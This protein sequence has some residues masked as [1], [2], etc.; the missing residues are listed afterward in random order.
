MGKL[1]GIPEWLVLVLGLLVALAAFVVWGRYSIGKA[2]RLLA[3]RRPSP[4]RE[5]FLAMLA[6]DVDEDVALWIWDQTTFYYRP[7]TP[8]PDD[9]LIRDARIDDDD[10][11]MDWLPE[12][13]ATRGLPWK[14][15]PDW[16]AEWELTVRNFARWLQL[17]LTRS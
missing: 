2:H 6:D 11:T 15:W 3:T 13:A 9:H 12:F 4:T 5:Q 7:L 1:L 17:G 8:H 14:E 10:V 16:P